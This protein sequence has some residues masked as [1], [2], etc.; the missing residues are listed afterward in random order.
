MRVLAISAA[1]AAALLLIIL[2]ALHTNPIQSRVLAW[3][4]GELERRFDLDL[5]ADDLHYN[6]A[7]RRVVLSNVRLAAIGH[8]DDPFFTAS[9]VTVQFPWAAYRGM[10]RFDEIDVDR[11]LVTITRD[12]NDRSNLPPGRPRD[13]NAP[14]RR[15]DVR[16]LTVNTLDFIYRD[17]RRSVEINAA[18]VR[19]DLDY[20]LGKGAVGPFAIDRGVEVRTRAQRVTVDPVKG[21]MAFDGSNVELADVSLM[22]SDGTFVMDGQVKRTLDQPNLNLRFSGTTDLTVAERWTTPPVSLAGPASIDAT[23]KGAPSQFVLDARV[24]TKDSTV[25]TEKAVAIDAQARLTPNGVSV[26]R[27]TITPATGGAVEATAEVGFG[28]QTPWW[29]AATWRGLDAAAAFRLADVRPLAFGAALTGKARIDAAPGEP[30]RL[31]A[32]NESTPRAARGTAPLAGVVDFLVERDRWKAAQR[33]RVGTTSVDGPIGGVWNRQSVIQSTF[34]GQLAVH[35]DNVGEAAR[36]AA[37]FGFAAPT[38]VQDA[39]GP[40]DATVKMGGVFSQ[41]RFTGSLSS[42]G[43]DFPSIGSATLSAN[44]DVSARVAARDRGRGCGNANGCPGAR[45]HQHSGKC[46]G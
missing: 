21:H 8:H 23:M 2:L 17:K 42:S 5:S 4:I 45:S 20:E 33:H 46:F 30:F 9:A 37:L 29:V 25:G 18:G 10:L 32:H 12:E 39:N 38:I 15:L 31:E 3:S 34:E 41:P 28:Q 40:V 14:T 26:S 11:G 36:Y 16:A 1:V 24:T 6:L 13:P 27:S 44:F 22:T 19:A 7:E 43:V 35:T